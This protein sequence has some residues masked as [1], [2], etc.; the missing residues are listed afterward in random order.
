MKEQKRSTTTL[1]TKRLLETFSSVDRSTV[2]RKWDSDQL[3]EGWE[4]HIRWLT[5]AYYQPDI[6][7]IE[8]FI[9]KFFDFLDGKITQDEFYEYQKINQIYIKYIQEY[10]NDFFIQGEFKWN[11]Q[12]LHI[13]INEKTFNEL[14]NDEYSRKLFLKRVKQIYVHEDTHKQQRKANKKGILTYRGLDGEIIDT[15]YFDQHFEADAYGRD[16][17]YIIEELH[18]NS[19]IDELLDIFSSENT[20]DPQT[21]FIIKSYK[22]NKLISEKNKHKFIRAFYDFIKKYE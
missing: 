17:A 20:G 11:S 6:N 18:P 9:Y 22:N 8:D 10:E 4:K 13:I 21:D 12:Q 19:T 15:T 5:E 7:F 2:V 1:A 3:T 14:Q 16:V